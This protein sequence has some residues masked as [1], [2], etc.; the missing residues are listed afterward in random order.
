MAYHLGA[1]GSKPCSLVSGAQ[2]KSLEQMW[3]LTQRIDQVNSARYYKSSKH[4]F[5]I[6]LSRFL[7][8]DHI[9]VVCY[10]I[11]KDILSCELALWIGF[12]L[13]ARRSN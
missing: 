1:S 4:S 13:R 5:G 6:A 7:T 2:R 3:R 12:E 8:M 9:A 10:A 11:V